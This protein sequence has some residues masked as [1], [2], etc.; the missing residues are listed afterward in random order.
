MSNLA[1]AL[2]PIFLLILAGAAMA[3][4]GFPGEGFWGPVDRAV[5]YVFFPAVLVRTLAMADFSSFNPLPLMAA[6]WGGL[7][8][9]GLGLLLT[10]QRIFRDGPAFTS[11]FQGALRFNTFVGLGVVN[12]LYGRDG[13]VYFA[14]AVA[15]CVP[16]LN[17]VSILA[18]ARH[19][20]REVSLTWQDQAKLVARNPLLLACLIGIG[21]N[22][23]GMPRPAA[24]VAFLEVL[25]RPTETLG[26]LTVGAGLNL[27]LLRQA[28]AN[29]IVSC[30][31]RL[32]VL[33]VL[34]AGTTWLFGLSGMARTIAILWAS[35]P[36][37]SSAY[38]LARQMGGD[39]PLMAG[40]VTAQTLGA[41]ATIPLM[42]ALLG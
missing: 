33:P 10:R 4:T 15:A 11:V 12:G 1:T 13:L 37:A 16:L 21:I 6:L 9:L 31:L 23:S 41:F 42:L 22:L 40:I 28:R 24:A 35:L 32:I 19:G 30:T 36:T 17:L 25:G 8:I 27:T 5:Y 39:A 18:L 2:L 26:L 7:L 38:I 3:R 20:V 29:L 34:I 14:V